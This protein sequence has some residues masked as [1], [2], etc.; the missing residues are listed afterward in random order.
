MTPP[1]HAEPATAYKYSNIVEVTS[2]PDQDAPAN[3]RSP[4]G[5]RIGILNGAGIALFVLCINIGTLV[6]ASTRQN[7]AIDNS[8]NSKSD[9]NYGLMLPAD[10]E[11][12]KTL[13]SGDCNYVRNLNIGSHLLINILSTLLL[14]AC[15]YAM[16]CLSAPTR[17]DID[18]MHAQ[19]RWLDIGVFS[20]HNLLKIGQNRRILWFLL[21]VTSL[22]LHLL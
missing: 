17:Q 20:M 11:G 3:W 21:A 15:N 12:R 9:D 22:P 8:P 16:Q 7:T 14:A 18:Q 19:R 13:Y 5:W 1:A 4:K 6:Y 10:A 2:A